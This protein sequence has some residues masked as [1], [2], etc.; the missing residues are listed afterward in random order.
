[1][2]GFSGAGPYEICQRFAVGQIGRAQ[3]V[4]ELA[5]WEYTPI[6]QPEWLEDIVPEPGPASWEEVETA[7]EDALIDDGVY[8]EVQQRRFP[9]QPA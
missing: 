9:Q 7:V 1:M 8:D 4:E 5:C 3:L 2:K 6:P